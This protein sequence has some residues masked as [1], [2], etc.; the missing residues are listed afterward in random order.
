MA[1][2]LNYPA[3]LYFLSILAV[4]LGCNFHRLELGA[5]DWHPDTTIKLLSILRSWTSDHQ[6]IPQLLL[7]ARLGIGIQRIIPFGARTCVLVPVKLCRLDE[8][9]LIHIRKHNGMTNIKMLPSCFHTTFHMSCFSAS[10]AIS[11]KL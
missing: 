4:T 5:R 1:R 11:T 8:I 2:S 10:L 7:T 3:N 9:L 6:L